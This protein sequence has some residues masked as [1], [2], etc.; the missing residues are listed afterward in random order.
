MPKPEGELH[1]ELDW[2]LFKQLVKMDNQAVAQA[3]AQALK[4]N[5][6]KHQARGQGSSCW[7]CVCSVCDDG[8]VRGCSMLVAV[9][10]AMLSPSRAADLLQHGP[11]LPAPHVLPFAQVGNQRAGGDDWQGIMR[12]APW[13]PQPGMGGKAAAAGQQQQQPAWGFDLPEEHSD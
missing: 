6:D 9:R 7:V 13:L 12:A 10:A 1:Q 8:A 4:Q 11:P 3:Q 5:L 2:P